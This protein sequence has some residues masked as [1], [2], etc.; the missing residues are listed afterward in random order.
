M[1]GRGTCAICGP[2]NKSE[3]DI[4]ALPR[5]F[6][7]FKLKSIAYCSYSSALAGPC[8][9]C[10]TKTVAGRINCPLIPALTTPCHE[11]K[12][13]SITYISIPGPNPAYPTT[14]IVTS[15]GACPTTAT[16]R[17]SCLVVTT[18][19]TG[20]SYDCGVSWE[21]G[22]PSSQ[23]SVT[24]EPV[25]TNSTYVSWEKPDEPATGAAPAT[26]TDPNCVPPPGYTHSVPA[27]LSCPSLAALSR[28]CVVPECAIITTTTVPGPNPALRSQ[29]QVGAARSQL[30]R[31]VRKQILRSSGDRRRALSAGTMR[32]ENQSPRLCQ[33]QT[34]R[35]GGAHQKP[36]NHRPPCVP[37]RCFVDEFLCPISP[38]QAPERRDLEAREDCSTTTATFYAGC[39]TCGADCATPK[40]SGYGT[41]GTTLSCPTA[42][43]TKPANCD[44][45]YCV[46]RVPRATSVAGVKERSEDRVG[47]E[48]TNTPTVTVLGKCCPIC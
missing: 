34:P 38:A 16:C 8:P 31:R 19:E 35:S 9:T 6:H 12:C 21:T 5:Y 42:T 7:M 22:T 11:L 37:T 45:V 4:I 3:L 29:Y 41:A 2:R 24:I 13:V 14:P 46:Q 36:A 33:K 15:Y 17:T 48:C 23:V 47:A 18:T 25:A 27:L 10:Y 20:T 44:E 43:G 30:A 40:S 26:T 32:E 28:P 39:P 1:P